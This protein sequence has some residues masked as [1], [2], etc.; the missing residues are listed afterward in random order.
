MISFHPATNTEL[1]KYNPCCTLRS[2]LICQ[3]VEERAPRKRR[4]RE[5]VAER[6]EKEKLS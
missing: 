2:S 6:G 4:E 5:E 3:D 1:A